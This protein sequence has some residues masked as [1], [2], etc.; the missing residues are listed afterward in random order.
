MNG[1]VLAGTPLSKTTLA[2]MIKLSESEKEE[3]AQDSSLYSEGWIENRILS[4]TWTDIKKEVMWIE[5]MQKRR[6]SFKDTLG[7]KDGDMFVP[8]TIFHV[9][10]E[11][12]YVYCTKTSDVEPNTQI[13]DAPYFNTKESVCIGSGFSGIHFNNK[14]DISEVMHNYS[15]MFWVSRF[16]E[17]HG[18]KYQKIII[19]LYKELLGTEKPFPIDKLIPSGKKLVDI[20]NKTL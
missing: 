8:P 4:I 7:L 19:D 11:R 13:Y 14:S 20:L 1:K 17:V 5:P 15:Q 6:L 3:I 9:I 12:L 18:N 16:S 10:N 2:Q